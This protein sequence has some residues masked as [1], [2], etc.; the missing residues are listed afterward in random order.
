MLP[1]SSAADVPVFMA[2]PTSAWASAG[3]SAAQ[4]RG[5]GHL[6]VRVGSDAPV[7]PLLD[8]QVPL[9]GPL[10]DGSHTAATTALTG[11]WRIG[12]RERIAR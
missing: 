2:T 7:D 3:A 11:P 12:P 4:V 10:V 5:P 1:A 6:G 8:P 9:F